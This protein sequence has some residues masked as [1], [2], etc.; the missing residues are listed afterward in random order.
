M[1]RIALTGLFLLFL[2]A[3]SSRLYPCTAF[4]IAKG[5]TILAGNNEDWFDPQTKMWFVPSENGDFGRVYFGFYN[6][7]PQG[8]MNEKGLFFDGFATEQHEVV[9][10]KDKPRYDG[11][12]I[13]KVMASCTTVEEVIEIFSKY[14]LEHMRSSMLMFGDAHGNSVIIE[15]DD[16]L[17]KEGD[18]QVCTNFY[19]S[20]TKPDDIECWRYLK[21]EE[22]LEA[23]SKASV[24]LCESILDA[25]HTE[26]TQY[27][28]IYDLKKRIVYL[29]HFHD[30][31]NVIEIDLLEE[32]KKEKNSYDIESLFP[33]K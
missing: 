33:D 24:Q 23:G 1:K 30:F 13:D 5:D 12:I 18:Y 20:K 8:G 27:S 2:L 9:K 25:V 15:G 22:M 32:L 17:L 16:F 6:F 4:Y 29:Y 28:N 19:Q 14:N 26:Y 7:F 21:A 31:D 10:S 11:I 3:L